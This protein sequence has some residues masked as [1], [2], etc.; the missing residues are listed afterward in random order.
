[1][2]AFLSHDW[3]GIVM[4]LVIG[5]VGFGVFSIGR[6]R[7]RKIIRWGL[8]GIG[9][10]VLVGGVVL[11]GGSL[12][13]V[14]K[15]A[16]LSRK[17]PPTGRLVDVG[18]GRMMHYMAE[19]ENRV[20]EG[21]RTPTVI[22]IGGGYSE[23]LTL[24]HLYRALA[25][26]TRAIIFDRAG[27][28]WSD[29]SPEPRTVR[30]DVEDLERMLDA[31]GEKGPFILSGHSWGGRFAINFAW[32]HPDETAGLVLLDASP[33]G[34]IVADSAPGLKMFGRYLE[35]SSILNL[36]S[37]GGLMPSLGGDGQMDPESE[38][39]IYKPIAD[40]WQMAEANNLR[41]RSGISAGQSFFDTL[42]DPGDQAKDPGDLDDI[43]LFVIY[44]E[45]MMSEQEQMS[46]E[47]REAAK[48]AAMKMMKMTEEEY[49]QYMEKAAVQMKQMTAAV[50]ALSSRGV[51]IHPPDPSTH[52][53]PYEHPEFC[54][55]KVREMV[56]LVT[57]GDEHET[58][59]EDEP[60]V[61]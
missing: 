2:G 30:N 42:A 29:Y 28:G 19:G 23:G 8:V 43:P 17:Y 16:S 40:V 54:A 53:F 50:V 44:R 41:S 22:F 18:G 45:N 6:K 24:H 9:G 13:H 4:A 51:L 27:T 39:F 38:S 55:E 32:I 33:P 25:R 7:E 15:I 47:E 59:E 58:T 61:S 26:D 14:S 21:V 5:L 37:L 1:M 3:A 52:Q 12:I 48:Q 57:A 10:L 34:M 36:F 60:N 31:A 11:L 35:M 20:I 49:E 46:E 56:A